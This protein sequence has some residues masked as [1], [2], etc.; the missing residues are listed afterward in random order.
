VGNGVLQELTKR[1][2]DVIRDYGLEEWA[3]RD[4]DFKEF[5][6]G[7]ASIQAIPP[8]QGCGKGG[9]R[10]DCEMRACVSDKKIA[11]CSICDETKACKNNGILQHMRKGALGAGLFVKTRRADSQRLVKKWTSELKIRWPSCILFLKDR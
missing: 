2:E 4:F 10:T 1:Y 6:E 7:I 3:Q 5:L 8:C 9:G 11:D